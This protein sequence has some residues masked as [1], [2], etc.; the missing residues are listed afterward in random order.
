MAGSTYSSNLK[1]ELMSTGENSGTWG[2]ITNTNL[3]TALEQAVVGYGNPEYSSDANLTISI[4]NSN[5]SQAARCLV[6]NVTSLLSLTATR[7]L[8][9]PTIQKQYIVQNNTTG[10][11]SI[12][13]KTSAGTGITVPNGKK[14]HLYVD[15]TNVI[16]MFDY[17]GTFNVDTLNATTLNATTLDL[18]NLEVTNIKAKDGTAGMQI[19]DSTGVVSFTA[20]PIMSG[21]TANGVAYLNGSKVLTTGS[22]LVFNGVA[23]KNQA[24]SSGASPVLLSLVNDTGAAANAT[25]IKLWMSGRADSA[26]DRGVYLEAV[27]TNTNNAHDLI[28]ATSASGSS[29]SERMR[30]TSAGNVGIGTSSPTNKLSVTGDANVTGNVTLGDATTDTVTVNGYMGVG[31]VLSAA[32][33][34]RVGSS[35]LTGTAQT[36]VNSAPVGTSAATSSVRAFVA[37]LETAAAAFTTSFTA[38]LLVND[39][40]KGAGS[41][42]TN[43][44]GIQ[45]SDQTQGTNNYGITSLVSSGTN[46]W[47][48]YASGTASNFFGG[49]TIISVTDNTNA[50]LRI[51][52]LGTGNAL[53]VEDSTN[54]DS[55]PVVVNNN[56][57]VVAGH[58]SAI[59]DSFGA[60]RILQSVSD[61][62]AAGLN[63]ARYS[64]DGNAAGISFLKSRSSSVG[65]QSVLSSGDFL[66]RLSFAGSDGTAFIEAA[67]IHSAVDG[68]PG[69]NDMPGRLVFSTTADGASSPTERM[70]LDSSGNLGIG[71]SS[72]TDRLHVVGLARVNASTYAAGYALTFQAL[73]ETSRTYQMGM[74]TGGNFAIYDS[75]AAAQ[76]VV[77]DSSGNLGLGVT[78]SAWDTAIF[79]TAQIGTGAGSVSLSG[80]SD[81]GKDM[82]LGSNIY[83]G[84]GNFRY[85]GTGVATMYRMDGAA[86]SWSTAASGTAGNAITFTQAMTL[87]ANGQL[88]IGTTSPASTLDV[89]TSTGATIIAGRT[90]NVG[91]TSVPGSLNFTAPNASGSA[92]TWAGVRAVVGTATA[93]SESA[94]IIFSNQISGSYVDSMTLNASGNVGIGTSSPT[95]KLSIQGAAFVGASFNGQTIGD[96]AA[97]RLRIGYKDGAP[98]TGLVPAQIVAS[99]SF[100]QI[101]S[102]DISTSAITFATGTGIPERMRIDSSGNV[103]IGTTT[104]YS[105]LNVYSTS[106]GDGISIEN[107]GTSSVAMR[108]AAENRING[109]TNVPL[110][111]FTNNTERMRLDSSGNLSIG[112]SSPS[113]KLDVYANTNA[114]NTILLR[115]ADT[116]TANYST[117][118]YFRLDVAGNHIGG[119]KTTARNLGGLSTQALYLTTAGAYPIAFGLNDSAN[120]SMVL[121]TSGNLQLSTGAFVVDA[122]APASISTAATLTNANIQAQIINTT[123]TTYTVTMPLGTTME[124]LVP[125]SQ[126][127]LGYDFTV[128]NTASGTITM[129]VN[130]GVTSLGGL[131]I[132]TGVSAQ[133]RIRRTA[134]NT[135]VLYRLS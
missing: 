59:S 69:T 95:Q 96:V 79:R 127:D 110:T 19:A 130:T 94:S 118:A 135:F 6:L 82:V 61:T 53:L 62:G 109:V 113:A 108:G 54:P 90:S 56:G 26:T 38:G 1:I 87:D 12:T 50:A 92:R 39:V 117:Q 120:P 58:T 84:T 17:M 134:A 74:V 28:F 31:G 97:E 121:D 101:A 67:R 16:Q 9:V 65:S 37:N 123:G 40:V 66:G 73:A 27:T 129:A 18:T 55:S 22:A 111:F 119:L 29:P 60:T 115:N 72:P 36:G 8:V 86:H 91:A 103:G 57:V 83:Y 116:N 102:R 48:I 100:L 75:T 128:I 35:A 3:G 7:E 124:T 41:T 51:T 89:R 93:G 45:I 126:T 85:V 112:T 5:A 71:T 49:N 122:P 44:Y 63:T 13:V 24:N 20:N 30:I 114:S 132:A 34:L 4:T 11:Q 21:G 131:T 68:T 106:S 125:W 10:G 42:I 99:T 64:A 43:Q 32:N 47:N 46:K 14:A 52:Q 133:F 23:L 33:G 80:R 98:D 76:R 78:P 104:M 107:T 88:G 70:R 105:K 77:L 81:G 15:G 2:D 25:G